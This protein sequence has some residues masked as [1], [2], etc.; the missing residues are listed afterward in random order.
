MA[1]EKEKKKSKD[2]AID[3]SDEM[4]RL[5]RVLGQIEGIKKMLEDGRKLA[6]VLTQCK[7]VHS[8][9]KSV[10]LRVIRVHFNSSLEDIL[11]AE[12]KKAKEEHV[13]EL[14]ELF[15]QMQQAA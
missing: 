7:A 2:I 5:N 14:A 15:K 9:L 6:D 13:E 10:E 4:K 8:A 11:K 1:K 3:F 12:K